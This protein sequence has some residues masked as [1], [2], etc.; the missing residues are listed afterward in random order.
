MIK[1]SANLWFIIL[2]VGLFSCAQDNGDTS[3]QD[4]VGREEA[5]W[6]DYE[7]PS[8]LWG[9]INRENRLVIPAEYDDARDFSEGLAAVN[10]KGKWGYVD[11]LG[12]RVIPPR[13]AE[14]RS[15]HEG[16]AAVKNFEGKMAF[17][18]RT[19]HPITDFSYLGLRSFLHGRAP[20][21]LESGWG[22]LNSSGKLVVPARY[23]AV[24]PFHTKKIA[25]VK[26][27]EKY[28]F[29]HR[30]GTV[31]KGPQ[32]EK[33][34][35]FSG[36]YYRYSAGGKW[37][38][39]DT[40]GQ[41]IVAAAYDHITPSEKGIYVLEKGGDYSL[42]PG[43]HPLS[44][45]ANTSQVKYVGEGRLRFYEGDSVGLLDTLG[46]LIVGPSFTQINLFSDGLA[47]C[48][49]SEEAWNWLKPD[50]S[51]LTPIDFPLAW[52]FYEGTARMITQEGIG[53]IDT[54]GR[55]LIPPSFY[56]LRDF[57]GGLARVQLAR[58]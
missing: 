7:T 13:F 5:Y 52:D 11:T 53:V 23:S 55:V 6:E 2:L 51:R 43:K 54:L 21:K 10:Y 24:W 19:G 38:V 39:L 17:I 33:I 56:E 32:R 25:R 29:I 34:T 36:G 1:N 35:P 49:R 47:L 22:Y 3:D 8:M 37:G 42:F 26:L 16:F 9:W 18:D 14:A 20:A 28:K 31:L 4:E 30:D 44:V 12:N 58:E 50:G 15:F 45:P 27:G 57:K 48:D 41:V 40:F 46:N